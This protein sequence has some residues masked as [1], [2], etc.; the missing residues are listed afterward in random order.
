[1][2]FCKL[3][4]DVYTNHLLYRSRLVM[5]TFL[6]LRCDWYQRFDSCRPSDAYIRISKLTIM[7]SH[8]RRQAIIWTSAEMLLIWTLE[9]HQWK[10]FVSASMCL[11]R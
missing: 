4:N 2:S 6:A 11:E 8:G 7:G 10:Q 5:N 3:D 9:T 1:M